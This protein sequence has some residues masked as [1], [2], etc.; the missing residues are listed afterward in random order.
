[1]NKTI[2]RW[3]Q[4]EDEWACEL[5]QETLS[6]SGEVHSCCLLPEARPYDGFGCLANIVSMLVG[7]L[8]FCSDYVKH[9][10]G[11]ILISVSS[12]LIKFESIWI[13]FIE[14]AWGAIHA[15][16][17]CVHNTSRSTT[18][19]NIDD[20]TSSG[21]RI[22]SFMT[23]LSDHRLNTSGQTMSSLFRV[24]HAILKFLKQSDSDL[25]DD[26]ICLSIHQ[27]HKMPWNLFHQ[28]HAGGLASCA[29]DSRISTSN[30]SAQSGILTGSLLQLLGSLLDQ[31]YLRDT[32]GQD[33]FVKLVDV[34]P[35]IALLSLGGQHDGSKSLYQYL[36]HKI[37]MV[38]MRLKP[39]I[40]QDCSHIVSWLKLLRRYFGDL[41]HQPISQHIAKP[42]NCL[43]DSPFLLDMVDLVESQDK[44]TRH[45]QRQAIYLFLSCSICL[46]YNRNDGALQCSCKRDECLLGHKVQGCSNHC[47]CFGLSEISDWFQKC[48]LNG[49]L[50]SKSSSFALSF[51]ELYMEEDDMLF[52]I[53]LQLLDAPL[54]FLKIANFETKELVGVKLFSSIFDPV[55]LFHLLLFLLHYDHMVL[56][57]YL[58]S[59][60]VGVLCAQYLLRCLRLVSQSWHAFVDDSVYSTKIEKLNCKRQRI[61]GDKDSDRASSSNQY[62]NGSGCDKEV[63]DSRKLFLDAKKCLYLLKRTL[64]DLQKKDL[65][66]YNPKPLLRSLAR[67]QE[68]GEQG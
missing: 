27:I 62:K 50:D 18:D 14:L 38:M 15:A 19:S 53:L 44:S 1:M 41:L 22:T 51:L 36:K 9:S 39:Y 4:E 2:R 59:R 66:P 34:V 13:Q 30:D 56:V 11:N 65:F 57:D 8:D 37:L 7:F 26:F 60:D 33:M 16:L 55:H 63:E 21:T 67:F 52:S 23:A 54:V 28:L 5:F 43:E 3:D 10:A 24:L 32:D 48:Y 20:S 68:L 58:I 12:T 49:S 46:S 61:S 42:E 29:K 64:E 45:L 25:K 17:K 6:D 40:Q 35:K 47:N 31:S